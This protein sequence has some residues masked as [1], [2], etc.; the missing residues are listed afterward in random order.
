MSDGNYNR[1][2]LPY[3]NYQS[4]VRAGKAQAKIKAIETLATLIEERLTMLSEE[5]KVKYIINQ[6][7]KYILENSS[8]IND[9]L[10]ILKNLLLQ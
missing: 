6:N 10:Y 5:E 4:G 1:N 3:H 8:D 2:L 9:S 7:W